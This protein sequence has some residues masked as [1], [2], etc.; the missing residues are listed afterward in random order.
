MLN[1]PNGVLVLPIVNN[2]VSNSAPERSGY[3]VSKGRLTDPIGEYNQPY[4][5]TIHTHPEEADPRVTG[6][7]DYAYLGHHNPGNWWIVMGIESNSIY[8]FGTSCKDCKGVMARITNDNGLTATDILT[9]K[10]AAMLMQIFYNL[11][12]Y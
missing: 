10:G 5:T 2:T 1:P 3:S 11:Q 12:K 4:V 9:P 7:K 6:W 8:A